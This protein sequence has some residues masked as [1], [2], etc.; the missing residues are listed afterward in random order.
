MRISRPL[1]AL[2]LS[3]SAATAGTLERGILRVDGKPF[4]PLGSWAAATTTPQDLARLGMNCVFRGAPSNEQQLTELRSYMRECAQYDIQVLIYPAYGGRGGD[5]RSAWP[6]DR[7]E[8][9]AQLA[10]EPN[11]LAWYIGDDIYLPHLEGL[12]R[13]AEFFREETPGIPTVG[14]YWIKPS[15]ELGTPF[16]EIVDISCQYDYPVPEKSFAEIQAFFDNQR[17]WYGYPFWTWIQAFMWRRTGHLLNVGDEGAGVLPE[18]EQVRL[19]SFAA[20]NRG[21]SGLLYFQHLTLH[22]MPNIAAEVAYTCREAGLFPQHLAAGE[23]AQRL[24]AEPDVVDATAFSRGLSTVVSLAVLGDHYHHWVDEGV[25]DNVRVTCPWPFEET[26][27][28]YLVQI[29][30][31]IQCT[32]EPAEQEGAVVVTIPRLELAGF[33]LLS[34]EVRDFTELRS[35]VAQATDQLTALAASGAACQ[36]QKVSQAVWQ[37]GL[38]NTRPDGGDVLMVPAARSAR[39]SAGFAVAAQ[40]AEAVRAWRTTLRLSRAAIDTVMGYL[41]RYKPSLPAEYDH[42]LFTPYG[43]HNLPAFAQAVSPQERWHFIRNWEIAGPFPLEWGG[44]SENVGEPEGFDRSY[45]PEQG[46]TPRAYFETIDG[47]RG[48]K[49]VET[50]L[51]GMLDFLPQFATTENVVCY[52]RCRVVAERGMDATLSL[53]SNDGAKVFLNGREVI[54][55]PGGRKADPHMD[56]VDVRLLPGSNEL[57]IK[58]MNLG[59]NWRLYASFDDADRELDYELR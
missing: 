19:M 27:R 9:V 14:D 6:E 4:Y 59:A 7:L 29:P 18:P 50:D 58:V 30:D 35:N 12:R 44:D 21:V 25:V 17:E 40:S 47:V 3:V 26:P 45:P 48:W 56:T 51:S 36:F 28:A 10:G 39:S 37:A 8:L 22:Q 38:Q 16:E 1:F 32:V 34:S 46:Y 52:A 11:L 23:I 43:I 53:G 31:V 33:V 54:S 2:L 41:E 13:T 42:V 24:D 5:S 20:I 55:R 57:L 15:E 49:E